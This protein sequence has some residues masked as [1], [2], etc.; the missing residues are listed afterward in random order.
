MKNRAYTFAIYMGL[1]A[2]IICSCS[3]DKIEDKCKDLDFTINELDILSSGC[4]YM[5]MPIESDVKHHLRLDDDKEI[6]IELIGQK[7]KLNELTIKLDDV[8]HAS[9]IFEDLNEGMRKISL[10]HQEICIDKYLFISK[11]KIVVV[12]KPAIK[13]SVVENTASAS[14]PKITD[15]ETT[16]YSSS[17]NTNTT[18]S[19]NSRSSKPSS[20][21][22]WDWR[23]V[24][25]IGQWVDI[26]KLR[27]SRDTPRKVPNNNITDVIPKNVD[28]NKSIEPIDTKPIEEE[29]K[30]IP[31]NN[32]TDALPKNVDKNK[33]IESIDI[34]PIEDDKNTE[35][36]NT[37]TESI[38]IDKSKDKAPEY[39]SKKANLSMHKT[40]DCPG[41]LD[42]NKKIITLFIKPTKY[43]ELMHVKVKSVG[44]SDCSISLKSD[45]GKDQSTISEKI[46]NQDSGSELSLLGLNIKLRP[47]ETYTLSIHA[48]D[49]ILKNLKGCTL[50]STSNSIVSVKGDTDFLFDLKFRH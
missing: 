31:N 20:G 25:G 17:Q 8:I 24:D 2:L 18:P 39:L 9:H 44:F 43:I 6:I 47:D 32:I 23:N 48:T 45:D 36:D 1:I 21:G 19:I 14:N 26:S 49:S 50:G 11:A 30:K 40:Q 22:P 15:Q 28:K 27:S 41:I 29:T 34:K 42:K 16:V 38:I 37:N 3:P 5:G 10:C 12:D 46:S 33:P 35:S 7:F 13:K 4:E